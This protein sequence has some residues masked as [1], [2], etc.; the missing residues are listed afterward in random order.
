MSLVENSTLGDEWEGIQIPPSALLS[1]EPPLETELHLRQLLLFMECL[2]WWWRD[3]F[4]E[5]PPEG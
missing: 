1:D 4:G 2:D 5:L 3:R